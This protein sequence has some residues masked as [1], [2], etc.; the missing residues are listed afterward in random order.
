LFC[1][2]RSCREDVF[3]N[4]DFAVGLPFDECVV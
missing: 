1:F 2:V 4:A 3:E